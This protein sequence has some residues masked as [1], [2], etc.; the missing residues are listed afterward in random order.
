MATSGAAL[1]T[2]AGARLGKAMALALAD[3][4]YDIAIHYRS[5]K[6]QADEVAALI[7]KTGRKAVTLK[8]DLSLE[9]ETAALVGAANAALG[10]L[11]LLVNSASVFEHDDINAM[12]RESWD[13]HIET[14]LRAPLKLTQD[15][16]RQ[17]EAGKDNLV[18]N[19]IDQRVLKLTPQFLSYTVSK[20]ALYSLTK[21]LAQALGPQGVRVN[22]I[23]PGPTL[24]NPRQ[25]DADWER[26]NRATVL[27]HGADPDDICGA[28]LYLVSAKA[29]TGQMIAV[30]GGQHLGWRTPDVLVK[31]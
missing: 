23:G 2:G 31:E 12:T 19:L 17:A 29:V 15:F 13:T 26:Q 28:L 7:E 25:S 5:S 30:D 20:S 27:G 24:K 21:T 14:N 6:A 8:A 1:V 22:A 10:P 4:G 11:R 18:V 16:A 3:A 9:D